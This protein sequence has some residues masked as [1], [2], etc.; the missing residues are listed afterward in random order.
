MA[1]WYKENKKAGRHCGAVS[2]RNRTLS[3]YNDSI[4]LRD[5]PCSC[6]M[7]YYVTKQQL[8]NSARKKIPMYATCC[9]IKVNGMMGMGKF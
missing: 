5:G 2:V 4:L 6:H 3:Q 9:K 7:R 8:N 1:G